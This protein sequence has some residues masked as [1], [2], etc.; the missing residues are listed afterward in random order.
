MRR[1]IVTDPRLQNIVND[2]YKG[3]RMPNVLGHGS[4]ADAARIERMSGQQIFGRDHVSKSQQY[5]N[6]IRNWFRRTPGAGATDSAAANGMLND[7]TN[8]LDPSKYPR[9]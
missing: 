9:V 2:L 4:T 3:D 5:M 7:M 1:P 8:A 6:A